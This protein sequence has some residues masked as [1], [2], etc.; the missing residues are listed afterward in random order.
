MDQQQQKINIKQQLADVAKA[1]EQSIEPTVANQL[2]LTT[3][4][5]TPE[6]QA[7]R[8]ELAPKVYSPPGSAPPPQKQLPSL[9]MPVPKGKESGRQA[10]QSAGT[11]GQA[12]SPWEYQPPQGNYEAVLD[13]NGKIMHFVK[14]GESQPLPP[15]TFVPSASSVGLWPSFK[16]GLGRQMNKTG[17]ALGFSPQEAI[18]KPY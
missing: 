8:Y 14:A 1:K 12:G 17:Q 5:G 11:F 13:E 4:A 7:L 3:Q 2:L 18:T 6:G 16:Y 10:V 9:D 15:D